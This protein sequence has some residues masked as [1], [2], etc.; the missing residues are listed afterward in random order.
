M[1]LVRLYESG[2]RLAALAALTGSAE[3][4]CRGPDRMALVRLYEALGGEEW[5]N[6]KNW[7]ITSGTSAENKRNDPCDDRKRWFGIG[8]ID[9]CDPYL[10]DILDDGSTS[11][12]LA[13]VRGSGLGCFA[14]R[15]TAINLPRNNLRG[16]LSVL[17]ELGDLTN[18][19]YIDLSWNAIT[20]G[21]PAEVGKI[22]N[23][24]ARSACRTAAASRI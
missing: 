20:G 4:H 15:I 3:A 5:T 13:A 21:I 10:D 18:L 23:M 14:G 9:P 12:H 22:S 1:T 8:F 19:S 24:Q 16:N 2:L 7:N 11:T 17:T 6:N